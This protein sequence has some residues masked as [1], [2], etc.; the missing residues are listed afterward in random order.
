MKRCLFMISFL[1]VTLAC[2]GMWAATIYVDVS[3]PGDAATNIQQ[4]VDAAHDGDVVE[5]G[6]GA[7]LLSAQ[8]TVTNAISIR[9]KEGASSTII[10]G[11][12]SNRCFH[13]TNPNVVLEGLTITRG[14]ASGGGGGGVYC[15]GGTIRNCVIRDCSARGSSAG[16]VLARGP[17]M[18][19]GCVISGNRA[20]FAGGLAA[21]AGGTISSTTVSGNTARVD[22]GGMSLGKGKSAVTNGIISCN[23]CGR[24]GGGV[25]TSYKSDA[26]LAKCVISGN[27]AGS[28]A[29]HGAGVHVT[30]T[31]AVR[32]ENCVLSGNSSAYRGGGIFNAGT[33]TVIGSRIDNNSAASEGGGIFN[34]KDRRFA[35]RGTVIAGNTAPEGADVCGVVVELTGE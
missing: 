28:E 13:L 20:D 24:N 10:D 8:I 33:T 6:L 1:A 3:A 29:S 31:A 32:L 34:F 23:T 15:E 35:V 17:V 26:L 27:T 2:Q 18:I 22:C 25:D 12:G 7:Y 14:S 5:I 30:G 21:F 4:A 16:G 11:M 9:G 19:E